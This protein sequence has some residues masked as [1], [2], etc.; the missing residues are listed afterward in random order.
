MRAVDSK[1]SGRRRALIVA[2]D[3]YSDQRLKSLRSPAH[4]VQ[5]LARV[6]GDSGA[7]GFDVQVVKNAP[8]HKLRRRI[9][10]FFQSGQ[11][12][13]LLV[14]HLSCH[15]LKDDYGHLYFAT[16]DTEYN[17]LDSTAVAADW[18][19][20]QIDRSRSGSIVVQLDCC[21]SG[22]FTSA[23][24]HRS[25]TDV[26]DISGHL[27]GERPHGRGCVIL[28]ASKS[29]E[30]AF[31]GDHRSGRGEASIFTRAVVS[32]IESGA[33]DLDGDG[34]VSVNELYDFVFEKVRT[35]TARQTPGI[36]ADVQGEIYMARSPRGPVNK[37]GSP[38]L[39]ALRPSGDREPA[40][41][42]TRRR[43]RGSR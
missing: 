29:T 28:T 34:V 39:P 23:A 5:D 10:A 36:W 32:G 7:G 9:D 40:P 2:T 22:A 3:E 1:L 37:D 8:E 20:R 33:A 4:D 18:L 13:E 12:D 24:R 11:R 19:R 31:E 35:E 14:L 43:R 27:A 17:S 26:I 15:G 6:L 25:A 21:Y 38:S 30:Y 41:G 16:I 42:L